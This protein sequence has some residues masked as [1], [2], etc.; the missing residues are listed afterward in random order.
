M[1]KDKGVP[2][3]RFEAFASVIKNRAAAN[4]ENYRQYCTAAVD[5]LRKALDR[6]EL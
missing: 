1:A 3:I 5:E 6:P 4:E 2:L